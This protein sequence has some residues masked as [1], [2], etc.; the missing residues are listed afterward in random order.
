MNDKFDGAYKIELSKDEFLNQL[1]NS[2]SNFQKKRV[3]T[4]KAI[5]RF[6]VE[7]NL[8]KVGFNTISS[9]SKKELR[10]IIL[11]AQEPQAE[12]P[13]AR[14]T[15]NGADSM[16]NEVIDSLNALK[17]EL[18]GT[19]LKPFLK[20]KACGA[21]ENLLNKIED[22]EKLKNIGLAGNISII[23]IVLID[24]VIGFKTIIAKVK[25]MKSKRD[26]KGSKEAK[27]E[28]TSTK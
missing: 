10:E 17:F 14:N 3:Y 2:W 11:K 20:D 26:L 19:D 6:A 4:T 25:A 8:V 24:S 12:A 22:D 15:S 18:Q 23:A 27:N 1:N 21:I 7:N 28:D 5:A 9:K 13:K 16:A